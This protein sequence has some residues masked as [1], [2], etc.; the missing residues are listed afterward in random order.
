MCINSEST[1]T[2]I[3]Q[4]SIQQQKGY[5]LLMSAT[6]WMNHK[7]IMLSERS[8]TQKTMYDFI[9]MIFWKGQD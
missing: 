4:N 5:K 3:Q 1:Q 6:T 8:Q 7:S 2:V 9:Y